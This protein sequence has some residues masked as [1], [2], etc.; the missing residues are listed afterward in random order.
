MGIT[1]LSAGTER[2]GAVAIVTG[3]EDDPGGSDEAAGAKEVM[4]EVEG[5]RR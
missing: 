1:T 3:E 4:R 2:V 5:S